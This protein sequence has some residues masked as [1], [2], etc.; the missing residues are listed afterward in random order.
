M[1]KVIPTILAHNKKEF[2]DRFNK[3]RKISKEIHIDLMDGKFV[4]HRSVKISDIPN[5]KKYSNVFEAHLMVTHP[6]EWV[7]KLKTKGF[8]RIIIHYESFRNNEDLFDLIKKVNKLKMDIFLAINPD[9]NVWKSLPFIHSIKGILFMGVHPGIEHQ[10]FIEKVYSKI[11]ELRGFNN[12]IFLQVDGGINLENSKR[13]AE[14]GVNSLNSGSYVS[15]SKY[16]QKALKG[17]IQ[18]FN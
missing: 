5:L 8:D 17:I 1:N 3:L 18:R 13:F 11:K 4:N 9:T 7:S 6:E 16:P 10:V 12:K 14:L 15:D 2:I